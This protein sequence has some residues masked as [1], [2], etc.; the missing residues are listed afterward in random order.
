MNSLASLARAAMLGSGD[1]H[2]LD[3]A[4]AAGIA[5]LGG[6]ILAA[7]PDAVPPCP[8]ETRPYIAPKAVELLMSVVQERDESLLEE[9]LQRIAQAGRV[10]PPE[11]VL[12]LLNLGQ[13]QLLPELRPHIR[14][15]IGVRGR[16]LAVHH[17]AWSYARSVDPQTA[18]ET[19][20]GKE[21]IQA[22]RQMRAADPAQARAWVQAAWQQEAA[23]ERAEFLKTFAIGLSMEDELFLENCLD[24]RSSHVRE[25]A[26]ELLVR[27]E[28][29][30][31][32]QRMWERVRPLVRLRSTV[33]RSAKKPKRAL[34]VTLPEE[35]RDEHAERDGLS[36]I[37]HCYSNERSRLVSPLS[38]MIG[39]VPP[40]LW[41]REFGLSPREILS[42]AWQNEHKQELVYGWTLATLA[43][44][45]AEWAEALVED[46]LQ[47][48][49]TS[50][51]RGP[52][53]VVARS[54][55]FPVSLI[56]LLK[57]QQ[58][59]RVIQ[60][61]IEPHTGKLRKRSPLPD[62]LAQYRRPWS[63]MMAETVVRCIQSR[64]DDDELRQHLLPDM[65]PYMPVEMADALASGWSPEDQ[66]R[67]EVKEFLSI[68]H[69]RQ[70][71]WRSLEE[72]S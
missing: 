6:R 67:R 42:L 12:E 48:H 52:T 44:Q 47:H 39:W 61:E 50:L 68:L 8:P 18:W 51:W 46:Y 27:L 34:E 40:Q 64:R 22:L 58:M 54:T 10:V 59:E 17:P 32:V 57:P 69:L 26:R 71:M 5:E 45:D 9:F 63:P 16:W 21:R 35:P 15:V 66:D 36:G 13:A 31:F 11:I 60:A 70:Q 65:A 1:P 38:Q 28:A 29:S 20:K 49:Q 43:T 19:G 62:I 14:T 30:R 3:K 7:C 37:R 56:V 24:D 23:D 25:A 41:N 33:S 2:I 72:P 4:I 55:I 53:S